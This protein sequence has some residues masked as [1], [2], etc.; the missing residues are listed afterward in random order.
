M[1]R[2]TSEGMIINICVY[3]YIFLY[4][5][6]C[7]YILFSSIKVSLKDTNKGEAKLHAITI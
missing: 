6:V 3:T 1:Y 2:I 7:I 4:I 5:C